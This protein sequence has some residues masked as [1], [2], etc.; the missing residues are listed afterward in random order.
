MAG[1]EKAQLVRT[2]KAENGAL[3]NVF[4]DGSRRWAGVDKKDR[5]RDGKNGKE[6]TNDHGSPETGDGYPLVP[7]GSE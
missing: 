6:F 1:P 3:F 7:L 5:L 4:S 2:E